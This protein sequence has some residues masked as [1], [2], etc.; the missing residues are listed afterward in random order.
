MPAPSAVNGQKLF[1][2]KSTADLAGGGQKTGEIG[3]NNETGTKKLCGNRVKLGVLHC[4]EFAAQSAACT[5]TD[6]GFLL[7]RG[8]KDGV[9]FAGMIASAE[10]LAGVCMSCGTSARAPGRWLHTVV[11]STLL[12]MKPQY[13][14]V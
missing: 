11:I 6:D 7:W 10:F 4:G 9:E 1:C 3:E 8:L 14:S 12:S 5:A 13:T 2:V